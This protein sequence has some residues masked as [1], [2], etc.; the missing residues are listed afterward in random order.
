L[1]LCLTVESF[2]ATAKNPTKRIKLF[3]SKEWS[4]NTIK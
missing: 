4:P 2:A 1:C 3:G